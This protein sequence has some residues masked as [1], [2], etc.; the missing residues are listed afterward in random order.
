[1][2]ALAQTPLPRLHP[3]TT[4]GP[5]VL[6]A[7]DATALSAWYRSVLGL[8]ELAADADAVVLGT[9]EGVP[10]LSLL[11]R[12]GAP[13]AGR[14]EPGLYHSAVLLPTRADLGRFLRHSAATGVRLAGASDHLVSE[15]VYLTDPEGNGLEVYRDRPRDEWPREGDGVHM[16][17]APFDLHG[18]MAAADA[19]GGRYEAVPAG[20]TM[21]HV[22]LKVA[23]LAAS[24]RFYI[25]LL[26]LDLMA[27]YPSAIFVAAGGYHHH[28]GLNEWES[29]GGVRSKGATGL[30]A[31]TVVLPAGQ[32][33]GLVARLAAAGVAIEP[34]VLPS[35]IDPSGNRLALSD[36]PVDAA[37][38]LAAFR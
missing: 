28:F 38:L 7:R 27:R 33:D 6:A 16:D 18:V 32:R 25:D 35:V 30:H 11:A 31:A 23:D 12:P 3:D 1:M 34:G 21:G 29:R 24:Q 36:G 37:G 2:S 20:T 8:A 19:G 22:H 5:V 17:N 9:A 13:V 14:R 26:G 15:A 10:L 4:V